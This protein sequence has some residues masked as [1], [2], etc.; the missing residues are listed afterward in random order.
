MRWFRFVLVGSWGGEKEGRDWVGCEGVVGLGRTFVMPVFVRRNEERK[1]RRKVR[2]SDVYMNLTNPISYIRVRYNP[3]YI[4][5]NIPQ[6]SQSV[7]WSGQTGI[8]GG[9]NIDILDPTSGMV[10]VRI[11]ERTIGTT[12]MRKTSGQCPRHLICCSF[13]FHDL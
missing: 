6:S 12:R 10:K 8:L 2:K 11:L 1:V 5:R 13:C 4:R 9:L 3:S 7:I